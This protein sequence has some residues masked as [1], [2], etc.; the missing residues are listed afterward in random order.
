MRRTWLG[1]LAVAVVAALPAVEAVRI[2]VQRSPLVL[3]GDEALL[4]LG[5]RRATHLDQLVGPYSRVG[6]HQPGP[7]IFYLLAPFV[8]LFKPGGP[9]LFLG[10]IVISGAALVATVV[11][12]YRRV[13][14][15]AALAGAIAIDLFCLCVQVGTLREPWNPYLVVAPMVLFVVLWAAGITG[16]PGAAVWAMV[17]GSYEVQTHVATAGF[18]VTMSAIMAAWILVAKR[19]GRRSRTAENRSWGPARITGLSALALIWLPPIVELWRDHPNNLN[20]LWDY[21][22]AGHAAP[23]LGQALNVTANAVTIV[24]FGYHDY[25]LALTR[26]GIELGIG[27]SL[28]AVGLVVAVVLGVRRRQPMSLALAA[29]SVLGATLGVVSLWRAGGPIYLYFAVWLAFV[30]LSLL[31]AI[32]VALFAPTQG[33]APAG[34]AGHREWGAP[35]LVVGRRIVAACAVLGI[36][37]AATTVRSDVQHGAGS[38]QCRCRALAGS[39]R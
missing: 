33:R 15:V 3:Y 12:L 4:E 6:F 13:G 31:L 30:P 17:I 22:T 28:M 35:S 34:L 23:T 16:S 36:L 18:V 37:V 7:A 1:W 38:D 5:A 26:S 32:S 20:L 11:V 10:A 24:P 21:F 8:R 2:M 19:Q 27:I 9:G 39:N 29:T 14:P 25:A